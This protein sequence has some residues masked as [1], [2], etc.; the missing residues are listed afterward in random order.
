[1]Q[2]QLQHFFFPP[3]S[4]SHEPW[5]SDPFPLEGQMEAWG[6]EP[7]WGYMDAKYRGKGPSPV[8]LGLLGAG[9]G[10]KAAV[11]ALRGGAE[12]LAGDSEG[13]FLN[14]ELEATSPGGCCG[15]GQ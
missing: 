4:C 1:M 2:T 6:A 8:V 10:A 9:L 12:V 11:L 5:G 3:F 15:G 13:P 14:I 7:V